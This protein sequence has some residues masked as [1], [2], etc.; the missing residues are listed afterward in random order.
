MH[1]KQ[2]EGLVLYYRSLSQTLR[3]Q[4]GGKVYKLALSSGLSCPNRDGV[5]DSRGC[6]FCAADG[7]GAFAATGAD[8]ACQM[9]SARA[10]VAFK[11]GKNPRYIAYFQSF[12]NTYGPP[13]YLRR[14]FTAAME[15]EDVVALS[16]ATRPDCLP[17]ETLA[18]LAELNQR[19]PVWV[20]LGLQTIHADTARL[21]LR[22]YDLPA[23]DEAVCQ[24]R[25]RG[26][27]VIVHQIIGLPGE[28]AEKI[29]Q[30]AD[31][32]AHSGVQGIKFHLLHVLEGTGLADLWRCG[33]YQCLTLE[34]YLPLLSGCVERMP[35]DMV[36][37]RLTG[38]GDKRRLLA[39]LWSGEKKRVLAAINAYFEEH[40]TTQGALY[41]GS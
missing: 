23:F 37:H 33:L 27:T 36:I 6:L 7:S 4:F 31:Y 26:I 41:H 21:I 39:P 40:N 3:S 16:V 15:P 19:K 32:I 34:E 11:A 29:F 30:T 2:G 20:E 25:A 13:D 18:L 22:G 10:K 8:L 38:D 12:T 24:L 17:P 9:E 1:K 14:I 35:P 28:N 5:L